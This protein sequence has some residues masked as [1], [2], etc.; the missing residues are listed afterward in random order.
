MN[1]LYP[2]PDLYNDKDDRLGGRLMLYR[3][4]SKSLNKQVA[5]VQDAN[6]PLIK[7]G[8]P[9]PVAVGGKEKIY[10]VREVKGFNITAD[11]LVYDIWID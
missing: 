4:F 9:I 8:D 10:C 6:W 5:E 11:K 2:R 1:F 7:K 3:I